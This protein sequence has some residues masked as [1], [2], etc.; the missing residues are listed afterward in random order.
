MIIASLGTGALG[1]P[2]RDYYLRDDAQFK[3]TRGQ[4]VDHVAKMFAL[5]GEDAAAAK[6]DADRILS[7]ESK[8]AE[9]TLPRV[10]ARKPENIYHP[11]KVA[12]LATMSPAVDWST[13]LR[14][15]G[16]DQESLNVSQPKYLIT[17]NRLLIEVAL[18]E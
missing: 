9:A 17:V 5:A 6:A 10:E 14:T 12:E 15:L 4:Y 18:E 13:Y 2:D 1:L 7:L 16:I 8:L 11:T 3:T